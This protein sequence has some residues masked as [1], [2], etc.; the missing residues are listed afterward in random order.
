MTLQV[1][2]NDP[3]E[4]AQGYVS[5]Y[6]LDLIFWEPEVLE[7]MIDRDRKIPKGLTI[8]HNI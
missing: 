7:G 8:S 4:L 1:T 5:G 2:L 6:E 3:S